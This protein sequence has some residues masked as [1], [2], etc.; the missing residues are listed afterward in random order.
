MTDLRTIPKVELHLHLEGAAQPDFVR[1]LAAEKGLSLDGVFAPDGSYL[2]NDLTSF[3]ATYFKASAAIVTPDDYCRLSEAVLAK[4]AADGVIYTEIFIAPD[5][6]AGGDHGAFPD[7]LAAISAGASAA[8]AAHGIEARFI[9][10]AI[11]NLGGAAA[12][13]AAQLAARHRGDWLTGWGLAAEERLGHAGDFVR[14]F[15]VAAEAGLGLTAHAGELAGAESVRATLDHLPVSRIGHGVRAVEDPSLVRRLSAEGVVLEVNP[16]SNVALEVFPSWQNH[17]I[18]RLRAAGVA[19]TVST[20]D[21]PYFHTDMVHEYDMLART[22]GWDA[23]RFRSLNL[24]AI[25]AAFCDDD[26]RRRIRQ[27]LES[28]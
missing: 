2:W 5:I 10:T 7:Y 22:F 13:R 24:T 9:A 21:P 18:E 26:T 19:V 27:R 4:C 3:L 20:D 12:E 1:E 14:A 17:P 16:G 28:A 23:D 25:D 8:R 11:R 6:F 15:A